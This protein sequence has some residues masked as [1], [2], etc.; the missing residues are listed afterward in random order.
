MHKDLKEYYVYIATNKTNKVLYTGHA[1]N[2]QKRIYEHKTKFYP[3]S[4]TARYNVNKLVY[5]E[6]YFDPL[7]MINREKQIK[8]LLRRKK[9]K[10]IEKENPEWKDLSEGWE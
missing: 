2:L 5:Y 9:I 1:N 7:S 4:F 10:L 3:K 8:N 6:I